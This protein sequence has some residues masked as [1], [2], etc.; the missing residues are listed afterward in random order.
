M[1]GLLKHSL[2][3]VTPTARSLSP[4]KYGAPVWSQGSSGRSGRIG[5]IAVESDAPIPT[6]LPHL[7][8]RAPWMAYYDIKAN[9]TRQGNIC[10]S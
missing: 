10:P 7:E 1:S 5:C 4:V 2:F 9:V 6:L 3:R 8:Q